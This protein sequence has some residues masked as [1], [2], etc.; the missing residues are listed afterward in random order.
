[1]KQMCADESKLTFPD[2]SGPHDD[3]SP[4][5]VCASAGGENLVCKGYT[6]PEFCGPHVTCQFS[7]TPADTHFGTCSNVRRRKAICARTAITRWKA[8]K[9]KAQICS[10]AL[11]VFGSK[12]HDHRPCPSL[13]VPHWATS[14]WTL[15]MRGPVLTV[16]QP[17]CEDSTSQMSAVCIRG[18]ELLFLQCFCE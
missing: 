3:P 16:S 1:M 6:F 18:A 4:N 12:S 13:S 11:S 7:S 5:K 17:R 9:S 2:F 14:M 8:G 10:Y 15:K